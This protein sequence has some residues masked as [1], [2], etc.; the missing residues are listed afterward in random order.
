MAEL[1]NRQAELHQTLLRISGAIQVLEEISKS[2]GSGAGRIA[3]I[4]AVLN[5]I[6]YR[7]MIASVADPP[8][9]PS[10]D[11]LAC[12]GTGWQVQPA[13]ACN[14][15]PRPTRVRRR[16]NAAAAEPR[17]SIPATRADRAVV[18]ADAIML[19]HL[20][21]LLAD[22]IHLAL[23]TNPRPITGPMQPPSARRCA[24]AQHRRNPPAPEAQIRADDG[25]GKPRPRRPPSPPDPDRGRSKRSS[26]FSRTGHRQGHHRNRADPGAPRPPR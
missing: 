8:I 24:A 11:H 16:S 4:T 19:T 26:G 5:V 23:P 3:R 6:D 21:S 12:A 20:E 25:H 18:S 22:A 1:Q 7:S 15:A 10:V 14:S 9:T 13:A 17:P 2:D